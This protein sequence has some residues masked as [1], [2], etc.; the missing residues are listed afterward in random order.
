MEGSPDAG[1]VQGEAAGQLA[2]ERPEA[3]YSVSLSVTSAGVSETLGLRNT[4]GFAVT[5]SGITISGENAAGFVLERAPTLPTTMAADELLELAVRFRPP[6][7]APTSTFSATLSAVAT[8]ESARDL[9]ATA[10]LYGLAMS[11]ANAE[12][13]L[14]QV[15]NTLGIAVDVGSTTLTLGTGNAPVGD[16]LL[17][18]RFVKASAAQ[19]VRLE[20]V[21]RY[22]P[23]EAADYGYYTG[24]APSVTLHPLGTM[25]R[26]PADN[27]ANRTLFP[28]LDLGALL[29]FDPGTDSFG[30]FAESQANVASLGSD[31]R[32]YQENALNDDQGNVQPVH[33]V[34]V[35]PLR[36]R[37]GDLIGNSYLLV[38]EEASNSDFQDYVFVISNVTP[39]SGLAP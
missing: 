33:R 29:T 14:S 39:A 20:V 9:T 15:L 25:S 22:S 23:L 18:N 4:F 16:E 7:N 1:G 21:A 17:V 13:T 27:V 30:L 11:T 32:L 37:S 12:A 19:P 31:G 5:V 34:R 35:F 26:G 2:F 38:C 8:R 10:S 28:P 6:A 36:S 3:V 24:V